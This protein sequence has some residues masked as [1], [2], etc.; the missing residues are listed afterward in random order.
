MGFNLRK[1]ITLKIMQSNIKD[2]REGNGRFGLINYRSI[3]NKRIYE[4]SMMFKMSVLMLFLSHNV[5]STVMLHATEM[6]EM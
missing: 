5:S 6:V 3:C 1:W 2:V 4:V